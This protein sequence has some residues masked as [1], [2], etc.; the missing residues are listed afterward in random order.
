MNK[1][2]VL[3]I[4][5]SWLLDMEMEKELI[6]DKVDTKGQIISKCPIGD[7]KPTKKPT[8]FCF[9]KDFCQSL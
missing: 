4:I 5:N 9:S 2:T 6:Q 7:F 3:P 1:Y 8:S